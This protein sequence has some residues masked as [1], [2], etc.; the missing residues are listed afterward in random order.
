MHYVEDMVTGAARI[1][2]EEDVVLGLERGNLAMP[3]VA[4]AARQG[5]SVAKGDQFTGWIS[6][7]RAPRSNDAGA[8]DRQRAMTWQRIVLAGAPATIEL[9][10][11][12]VETPRI[13][14]RPGPLGDPCVVT[15]HGG[16]SRIEQTEAGS[17]RL[18]GR[19][20][21]QIHLVRPGDSAGALHR[22]IGFPQW[23]T[24]PLQQQQL[25]LSL[26]HI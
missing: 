19:S 20:P 25:V 14:V 7:Q 24:W 8:G 26:I 11:L 21:R 5:R 17:D 12:Q 10:G 16:A 23:T 22:A 6:R 15:A 2:L 18:V 13:T 1:T 3:G 4:R 9:P